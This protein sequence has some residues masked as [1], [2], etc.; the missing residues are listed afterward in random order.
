MKGY[1]RSRWSD[2]RDA[3]H[4]WR[5]IVGADVSRVWPLSWTQNLKTKSTGECHFQSIERPSR[6]TQTTNRAED[7]FGWQ[8]WWGRGRSR[9]ELRNLGH[10]EQNFL[11]RKSPTPKYKFQRSLCFRGKRIAIGG[12]SDFL[13]ASFGLH[14]PQSVVWSKWWNRTCRI[15]NR[16]FRKWIGFYCDRHSRDHDQK[17]LPMIR[18]ISYYFNHHLQISRF[19][20]LWLL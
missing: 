7:L 11:P 15:G 2:W 1:R 17:C 20:F 18:S 12:C 13:S 19:C 16:R 14:L 9:W 5:K 4:S 3:K 8:W 6:P 10:A